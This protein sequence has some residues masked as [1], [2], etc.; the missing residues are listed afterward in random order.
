MIIKNK[1]FKKNLFKSKNSIIN[2]IKKKRT[3]VIIGKDAKF[4]YRLT[5]FSQRLTM[6]FIVNWAK[7]MM[8][9]QK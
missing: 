1:E 8:K 6:S 7:K 3:K 2:A 4:M 9:I 5:R